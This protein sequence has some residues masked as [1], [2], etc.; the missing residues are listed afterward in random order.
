MVPTNPPLPV[1][2]D[3]GPGEAVG[4]L[5]DGL[6][7]RLMGMCFLDASRAGVIPRTPTVRTG[8]N[9]TI[10]RGR[11]AMEDVFGAQRKVGKLAAWDGLK[12]WLKGDR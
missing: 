11:R 6:E 10:S 5:L 2:T 4:W 8:T 1:L 9:L 7:R 3:V 12:A